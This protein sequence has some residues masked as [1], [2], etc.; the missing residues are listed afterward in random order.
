VA[1]FVAPLLT[2]PRWGDD[3]RMLTP[4][5]V[6]QFGQGKGGLNGLAQPNFV[7]KQQSR[8]AAANDC[9]S[10]LELE[11]KNVDAGRPCC[12]QLAE[13]MRVCTMYL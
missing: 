12:A 2:Q 11:W 8:C 5:P 7:R 6:V 9:Q 1:Q 3:E 4:A 10:R 13:C